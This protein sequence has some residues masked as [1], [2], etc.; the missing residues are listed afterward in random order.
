MASDQFYKRTRKSI[1]AFIGWMIGAFQVVFLSGFPIEGQTIA[2]KLS[3]ISFSGLPMALVAVGVAYLVD[4]KRSTR[5]W[6]ADKPAPAAR[7]PMRIVTVVGESYYQDA[8]EELT[9]GRTYDGHELPVTA[10]LIPE[11]DNTHD[12][13][14]VRVE[15][16]GLRVG[17]L[18][19]ANAR[20]FRKRCQMAQECTGVIVDGWDRGDGDRG[21]FG[22]RLDFG[23][24]AQ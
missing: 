10:T 12:P 19:R 9:G 23:G 16:D 18:S 11:D 3:Y 8:F 15:V 20:Q 24:L 14:A 6:D 2:G 22:L 5:M 17:Y 1:F 21:H 4:L 13:K 7:S